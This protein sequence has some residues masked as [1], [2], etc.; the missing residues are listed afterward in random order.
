MESQEP[1]AHTVSRQAGLLVCLLPLMILMVAPFVGAAQ[2]AG[3]QAEIEYLLNVLGASQCRF[4]RNGTWYTGDQARSH[5]KEKLSLVD[6]RSHIQTAEQFIDK[7]A[8]RSAL[9]GIRYQIQCPGAG[10]TLVADWLQQELRDYRRCASSGTLCDSRSLS[11]G[12]G[13]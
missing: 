3:P 5:L 1:V 6:T 12:A 4:Y 7:V 2:P 13:P 8:S 9:T 11:R 10:A